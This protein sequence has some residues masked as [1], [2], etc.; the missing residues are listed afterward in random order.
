MLR[1]RETLPLLEELRVVA[2][3]VEI[4]E[5]STCN[6]DSYANEDQPGMIDGE[7]LLLNEDQRDGLENW[8]MWWSAKTVRVTEWLANSRA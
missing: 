4:D 8:W 7:A 3:G 2:V 6:T 1:R 5:G